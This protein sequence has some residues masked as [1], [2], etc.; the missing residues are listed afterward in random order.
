MN[1]FSAKSIMIDAVKSKLK[2][3]G[4]NKITLMF[5]VN[6]DKYNIM[7]SNQDGTATKLDLTENDMSMLKKML[8][9]KIVAKYKEKEGKEVHTVSVQIDLSKDQFDVFIG[10]S[11]NN[12]D[13]FN[14]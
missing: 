11:K 7:L 3:T 5:F 2:G 10:D 8:I 4:V 12:I 9:N 1:P 13:K 14:Y 6:T